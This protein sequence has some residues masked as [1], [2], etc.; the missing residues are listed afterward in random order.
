MLAVVT[1]SGLTLSPGPAS[2]AQRALERPLLAEPGSIDPQQSLSA[3]A[4]GIIQDLFVG[5]LAPGPNGEAQA[6]CA[7]SWNVDAQ[8]KV[9]RFKLRPNL[10]WS[11]GTAL[12]SED[13]VYSLRRLL[14]Y[15]EIGR[16]SCRERV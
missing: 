2:A 11:D 3:G 6:A 5:L 7:Q 9:Y 1:V 16:A 12:T 8:G 15:M 4:G 14:R 13:F 10:R